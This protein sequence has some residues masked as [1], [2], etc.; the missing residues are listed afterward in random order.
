MTQKSF[1]GVGV[2]LV[3]PFRSNKQIDF[4]ALA[5]LINHVIDGGV[6]YVVSLG[7]T[8][9]NATLLKAEKWDVFDYTL[10]VVNKR[11]PVVAGWG[12]NNTRSLLQGFNEYDFTKFDAIL[13]V[14]PYYNKPSQEGIFQHYNQ[15][16][17]H[18]PVPM[19]V[20]NVPGRTSSNITA[21]TALR[22]RKAH[23]NIK[24]IKEASGDLAQCMRLVKGNKYDD[25]SVLSGDDNLTLPMISFGMDGVIS[26]IAN[27]FP[28]HYTRLVRAALAGDFVTAQRLQMQLLHIM[29]L[30]FVEGNPA[31]V[32]AALQILGIG[33]NQLRLPL[34]GVSSGTYGALERATSALFADVNA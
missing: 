22:L 21:A 4:D 3:T 10:Q 31:G 2:A 24:G 20:Y 11:V 15:L 27:A 34:V 33:N 8:G 6:N 16:A 26:V 17:L 30:L 29:D 28:A 13:S 23:A 18:T 7:T 9:E 14:N 19:I 12:G 1:S 5:K 32:K 25:F